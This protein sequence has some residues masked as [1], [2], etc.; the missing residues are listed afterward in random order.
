MNPGVGSC[1]NAR[2]IFASNVDVSFDC[3]CGKYSLCEELDN[4]KLACSHCFD[5]LPKNAYFAL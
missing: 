5:L 1:P 4:L 3:L 2:P